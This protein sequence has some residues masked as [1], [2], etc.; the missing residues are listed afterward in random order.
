[1]VQTIQ[2]SDYWVKVRGATFFD[3]LNTLQKNTLATSMK[4]AFAKVYLCTAL[5]ETTKI[6]IKVQKVG[7][8]WEPAI[9]RETSKRLARTSASTAIS[10]L[11]LNI[12]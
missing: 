5:G 2:K 3:Q 6:A 8:S 11:S 12:Q 9:L 10:G 7:M 4:G 1:M